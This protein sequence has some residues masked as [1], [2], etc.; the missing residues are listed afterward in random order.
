MINTIIDYDC[1]IIEYLGIR[2]PISISYFLDLDSNFKRLEFLERVSYEYIF[3]NVDS[4]PFN[5]KKELFLEL[6]KRIELE[7][8]LDL[9]PDVEICQ[10]NAETKEIE[11]CI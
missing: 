3:N 2:K 8:S 9:N 4:L 7:S 5:K 11:D 10:Y 6:K 1:I